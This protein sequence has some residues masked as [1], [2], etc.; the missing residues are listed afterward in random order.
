MS[1]SRSTPVISTDELLKVKG[2]A[3]RLRAAL[4]PDGIH[5]VTTSMLHNDYEARCLMLVKLT[6]EDEPLSVWVT[7]PLKQFNKLERMELPADISQ[8]DEL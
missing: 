3:P 6:G 8:E 2:L 4:D 7:I 1:E 5:V